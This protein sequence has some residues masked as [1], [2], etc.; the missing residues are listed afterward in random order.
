MKHILGEDAIKSELTY[1]CISSNYVILSETITK[2][3]TPGQKLV[4]QIELVTTSVEAL[5]SVTG[6]DVSKFISWKLNPIIEKNDR[7]ED[8]KRFGIFLN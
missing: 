8:L 3:E 6:S 2:L 5:N 4:N 7:F 1:T